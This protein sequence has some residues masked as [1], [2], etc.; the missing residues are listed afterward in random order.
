[1]IIVNALP[2]ISA[3]EDVLVCEEESILLAASG[4]GVDGNYNWDNGVVN[5]IDFIPIVSGTYHVIGQDSNGCVNND[6]LVLTI[7]PLPT[8]NAGEDQL[9]C[10]DSL[11]TLSVVDP[12]IAYSYSWNNGVVS[13]ESFQANYEGTEG[14]TLTAVSSDGCIR[15]DEVLITIINCDTLLILP[16]GFSPNNDGVNDYLVFTGIPLDQTMALVVF[17][18]WGMTLFESNDYQNDWD[19]TNQVGTAFVKGKELPVGT[20]YYVLRYGNEV[21]KN[22]LYIER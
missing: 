22:Y 20:Y 19:G 7:L 18:E 3:G 13:G 2:I 17:N 8:V 1:L 14:Y 4:A 16:T 6:S 15:S 11:I 5:G 12:D 9:V 21:V 10:L